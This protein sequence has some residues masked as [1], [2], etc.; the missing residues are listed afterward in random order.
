MRA[1][2]SSILSAETLSP[3]RLLLILAAILG[4]AFALRVGTRLVQ[5]EAHY[6]AN[7]Y[8]YLYTLAEGVTRGAGFCQSAGCERPPLYLTFLAL[9]K[10]AGK[11]WL[12]VV[13]PQALMGA[14][15]ALLAFLIGRRL[16]TPVTGLLSAAGVAFYPYYVM[17]DTALQDTAMTTFVVALSVWLLVRAA[18][19][20]RA[21][22]WLMAGLALGALVLV[23]AAM[24]PSA[25]AVLAWA[26]V[27]GPSGSHAHRLRNAMI[28]LAA[29][30][31]TVSP[32]LAYTYRVTGTPA[33][34]TDSGYLLWQGNNPGVFAYYPAES[35]DRSVFEEFSR[36]PRNDQA[37]ID[38]YSSDPATISERYKRRAIE[39][40]REDPWRTA[41]YA[42]RK[43][44]AA[45][46]WTF[47]PY[48]GQLAQWAYAASYVPVML[49]GI[50]GMVLT[51]R[52][53]ETML[54]AMLYLAFIGVSAVFFAHTSHRSYLDIYWIVFAAEMLRQA[55]AAKPPASSNF[56]NR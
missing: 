12:L 25:A 14:G 23:R 5:G 49:L 55:S 18:Q 16:F 37:Q 40:M 24:A 42:A 35:I 7:S 29:I 3:R 19:E 38:R 53:P 48:R 6:W 2:F 51:R 9:T 27:W 46:S 20:D 34:T 32:W 21:R 41:Q 4:A 1:T 50:A 11:N 47:N 56:M 33:L 45:F 17:H 28:L 13:I 26:L 10:F 15:T 22:D 8:S 31:V 39:F 43:L 36:L 30:S 44:T 52:R 54:I